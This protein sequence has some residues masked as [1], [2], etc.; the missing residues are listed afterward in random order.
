M[1]LQLFRHGRIVA[2][3]LGAGVQDDRVIENWDEIRTVLHTVRAGRSSGAT[4]ALGILHAATG[5]RFLEGQAR[6]R[7]AAPA[8]A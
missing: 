6:R 4:E 5:V 2:G 8:G 1:R 3:E 7:P